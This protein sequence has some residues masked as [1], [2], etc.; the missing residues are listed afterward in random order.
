MW[1]KTIGLG[2]SVHPLTAESARQADRIL[3]RMKVALIL[4][5]LHMPGVRGHHFL[6]VLRKRGE[7][8]PVV[9]I[10]A[11]VY[12]DMA[13]QLIQNRVHDP[14]WPDTYVG[15][16]TQHLQFSAFNMNDPNVV[17]YPSETDPAWPNCVDAADVVLNSIEPL[18]NANH[19]HA[20]D[21]WPKWAR[22]DREVAREGGHVF[23]KL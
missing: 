2:L 9:V 21:I 7:K 22:L 4:L 17:K 5:D 6:E 14:R 18:T 19:Y 23:Y 3:T 1:P 11:W 15:V 16:I 12:K 20:K 10:S 13:K 8:T